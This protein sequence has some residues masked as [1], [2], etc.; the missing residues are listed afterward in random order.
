MLRR[1]QARRTLGL[2]TTRPGLNVGGHSR[3][4][5]RVVRRFG[6]VLIR[7][8]ERDF[9]EVLTVYTGNGDSTE[10]SLGVCSCTDPTVRNFRD[11]SDSYSALSA[12]HF[13]P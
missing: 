13:P 5:A 11:G 1:D 8:D 3:A 9:R 12:Y 2:F 4:V 7:R 10:A 6:D